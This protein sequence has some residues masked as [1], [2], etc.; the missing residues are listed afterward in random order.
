MIAAVINRLD[1]GDLEKLFLGVRTRTSLQRAL[2][3]AR[4]DV[5][6]Q[7]VKNNTVSEWFNHYLQWGETPTETKIREKKEGKR[8]ESDWENQETELLT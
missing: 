4:G 3:Q 8:R 6:H 1:A 2:T 5:E 7:G